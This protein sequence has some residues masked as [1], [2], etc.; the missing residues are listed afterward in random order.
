MKRIY[1]RGLAISLC[2]LGIAAWVE[3]ATIAQEPE[4]E[5]E[6]EHEHEQ[7]QEGGHDN[8][9]DEHKD[10]DH[11]ESHDDHGH[12][13]KSESANVG[14]DKGMLSFSEKEGFKLSPE[15]TR[16]FGIRSEAV[17]SG[18]RVSVPASALVRT[19]GE[20]FVYRLRVGNYKRVAV[21]IENRAGASVQLA[22]K[23]L[24][25]G[26]QVVTQGGAFLRVAELD[27]TSGESG[28]HH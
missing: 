24:S 7:K 19:N 11:G 20:V 14:P 27:A 25:E 21:R 22:S 4:H 9:G 3:R 6:H 17:K 26:D 28:H 16:T 5:H 2:F 13:K 10:E 18:A 23:G 1:R 8:E 12:E 15:A